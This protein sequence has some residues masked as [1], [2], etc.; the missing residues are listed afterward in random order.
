M[1][2]HIGADTKSGLIHAV[3][4]T[5]ANEH[6]SQVLP[7]HIKRLWGYA[8]TRYRGLAKNTNRQIAMCA[9]HN[10]RHAG[11]TLAG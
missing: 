5:A 1:K 11:I 2:L 10:V 6:D 9:L 4:T 7:L 8:K 3:A